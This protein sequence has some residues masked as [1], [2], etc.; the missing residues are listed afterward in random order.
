VNHVETVSHRRCGGQS[1]N[2]G[3]QNLFQI[4]GGQRAVTGLNLNCSHIRGE[5]RAITWVE[6]NV[7]HRW[8]TKS[9]YRSGSKLIYHGVR[10]NNL[11]HGLR[12]TVSY[13]WV[14][15]NGWE[16]GGDK[17]FSHGVGNKNLSH[18]WKEGYEMGGEIVAKWVIVDTWVG[19]EY[20]DKISHRRELGVVTWKS[21]HRWKSEK[22]IVTW[23]KRTYLNIQYA[24]TRS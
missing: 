10:V 6:R 16:T 19:W 15:N 9:Y 1:C 13:A 8:G 3:G 21:F 23:M 18:E 20:M 2:M 14:G 7:S 22:R 17:L 12:R 11:S 4:C 5:Q 24:T